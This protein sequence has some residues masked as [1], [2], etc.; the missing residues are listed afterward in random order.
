MT[1][2]IYNIKTIREKK[3]DTLNLGEYN[4]L[5]GLCES[6]FVVTLYGHSG[7]GKSVFALRF[8]DF[9]AKNIGKTLYNSHEEKINQTIRDRINE[10]NINAPRLFFGNAL[11]FGRMVDV[12]RKNHYRTVVIDSVKYMDFTDDNLK[13][14]REIFA[15]RKLAIVM[16]NFGD[17]L[18]IPAG[19]WG[20]D[21]LHASDVKCFFK[22]GR[23]N[24]TSRYLQT[25]VDQVL[26]GKKSCGS[27][28]SLF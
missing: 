5:F 12:I 15:R 16:V 17:K 1:R 28:L 25:P 18:G 14:L 24:V 27:Q 3:Y 8:A 13:E 9:M 11:K 19:T 20:K 10:W 6:R 22:G 7:S 2:D 23:L 21:L 26:F 4:K